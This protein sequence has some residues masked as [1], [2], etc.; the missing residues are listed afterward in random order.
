ML[1]WTVIFRLYTGE[2]TDFTL[3][4]F[5][6]GYQRNGYSCTLFGR[7]LSVFT[8]AFSF[9]STW[10]K[11]G[12]GVHLGKGFTWGRRRSYKCG[13]A[14]LFPPTHYWYSTGDSIGIEGGG[15]LYST[16]PIVCPCRK[17]VKTVRAEAHGVHRTGMGAW[18]VGCPADLGA[19]TIRNKGGGGRG[20]G[21]EDGG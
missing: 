17:K 18:K 2:K 3:M 21:T 15:A 20:Q 14:P 11:S 6:S 13:M 19:D 10:L 12:G 8:W 16:L 1:V 4:K 7:E 5:Y 9:S